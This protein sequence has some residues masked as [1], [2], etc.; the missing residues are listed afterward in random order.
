[1]DK[2]K[3][4]ASYVASGHRVGMGKGRTGQG[5]FRVVFRSSF[6]GSAATIIRSYSTYGVLGREVPKMLKRKKK[7]T[8]SQTDR[9]TLPTYLL[10]LLNFPSIHLPSLLSP[11]SPLSSLPSPPIYFSKLTHTQNTTT[12]Q[13]PT[14]F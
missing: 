3:Y 9:Q 8:A 10:Y 12:K 11:L 4:D 5:R 6:Q 1:M 13:N 2:V 7:K 14:E